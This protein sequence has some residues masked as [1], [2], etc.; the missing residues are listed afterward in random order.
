MN[1]DLPRD[2][3][4][5]PRS[6]ATLLA[7]LRGLVTR[8]P[9]PVASPAPVP[10]PAPERKRAAPAFGAGAIAAGV[11][12]HLAWP[13]RRAPYRSTAPADRG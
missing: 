9:V 11:I 13:G 3:Y 12:A 8:K 5:P 2:G 7:R 10:A 4:T 6:L 1:Y